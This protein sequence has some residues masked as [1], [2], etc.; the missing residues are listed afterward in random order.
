MCFL[1][2][3]RTG[4]AF[5]YVK[6]LSFWN[7]RYF[8]YYLPTSLQ[9]KTYS[10]CFSCFKAPL[11]N[12]KHQ[13]IALENL[14]SKLVFWK[15]F[16][17]SFYLPCQKNKRALS[18]NFAGTIYR[19]LKNQKTYLCENYPGKEYHFYVVTSTI[20]RYILKVRDTFLIPWIIIIIQLV[21]K[22]S[23]NTPEI[24]SRIHV[25]LEGFYGRWK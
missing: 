2:Q 24:L 22:K 6:K 11:T 10:Y 9:L 21:Y 1:L 16:S 14:R 3:F 5:F 18:V 19:I 15:E 7:T 4:A 20:K 8:T 12:L 17:A 25:K 23:I 13:F